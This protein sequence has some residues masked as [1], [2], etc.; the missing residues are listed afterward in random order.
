MD[1]FSKP[2]NVWGKLRFTC[3]LGFT[4]AGLLI[5]FHLFRSLSGDSVLNS[6]LLLEILDF[7]LLFFTGA[8]FSG[9]MEQKEIR[10]RAILHELHA[11]ERRHQELLLDQFRTEIEKI[12]PLLDQNAVNTGDIKRH[13]IIDLIQK[14]FPDLNDKS[15]GTVLSILYDHKL[16]CNENSMVALEAVSWIGTEI[17][18]KYF[19]GISLRNTDFRKSRM[20]GT[21]LESSCLSGCDLRRSVFRNANLRGSNLRKANLQNANL[22]NADL[23]GS[24]LRE[25][26]LLD[27]YLMGANLLNCKLGNTILNAMNIPEKLDSAILISTIIPDGRKITN[28]K[29]KQY[30]RKKE[31][32]MIVDKL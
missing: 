23:E 9:W 29:G 31:Y 19:P 4:V 22:E 5:V 17:S 12:A 7:F 1:L 3:M 25:A 8:F 10:K 2:K 24:D 11:A 20:T 14:I 21:D 32:E 27:T 26:D 15:K 13:P 18:D 30:L 16:I 6:N 28:E